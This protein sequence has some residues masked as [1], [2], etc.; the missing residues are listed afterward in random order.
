MYKIMLAEDEQEVLNAMLGLI[1]WERHGFEPPI[2]CRDGREAIACLEGGFVPDAVITDICMPFVDGLA[3][4]RYLNEHV[5]E[6]IVVVLTGYDDFAYAQKAIQLQVYDYVL[7]P[8][9]PARINDLI[10]R[11][12]E[13]LDTLQHRDDT[14]RIVSSHFLNRLVTKK[15][16]NTTITENCK[17]HRLEFPRRYHI[18]ALLDVDLPTPITTEET[19]F[20]EL[21]RYGLCNIAQEL[22]ENFSGALVFQGN[23]GGGILIM[24][25]DTTEHLYAQAPTLAKLIS[26]TVR[27]NLNLTVSAGIGEP[28]AY[29]DELPLSHQQ[30]ATALSYRFFYGESSIL[31]SADIDI[32]KAQDVD[33]LSFSHQM[34]SAVKTMDCDAAQSVVSQLMQA[35]RDSHIPFDRCVL[36]C[37]KLVMTMLALVDTLL[38]RQEL[39]ALDSLLDQINFYT[40]PN[41]AKMEQILLEICQRAFAGLN[42]VKTDSAATQV[43][44]AEA[45][46]KKNYADPNLSLNVLTEHLSIS[47]SYFSAIFKSKT[48]TT[49]VEYLTR[50]RMEKAKQ[51][52][53]MTDRRTYEIAEDVGFSD[54]HYF[55][56]AF[57]RVVG[58]T[59][60]EYREYCQK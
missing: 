59:P 55:S 3:L 15:L 40:A 29:L 46:I 56:V 4:T 34:E 50:L 58:M 57:K 25:A 60:K 6:A 19:N 54:P 45:F 48:G 5:P 35:L 39:E 10:A 22:A 14:L 43:L 7:K 53:S 17:I 12:K 16:D 13:R 23:D 26:S 28:V 31:C 51:V 11:L 27:E 8:V 1:Q 42:A 44:R 2:G 36:Y 30:A 38:G 37:Q 41:L 21:M 52:L 24:G 32:K 20:L 49:F 47:T 33:Y 18:V 9:T